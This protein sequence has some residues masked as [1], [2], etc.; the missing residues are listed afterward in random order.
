[1]M[2]LCEVCGLVC[3]GPYNLKVHFRTHTGSKPYMCM[4]CGARFARKG[5]LMVH[6]EVSH[7]NIKKYKCDIC[8][9]DVVSRAVL[10]NHMRSHTGEKPFRCPDCNRAFSLKGNLRRHV[11]TVHA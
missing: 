3:K 6:V 11:K 8:G 5:G 2:H 7:L 4:W 10:T 9:L 1:M